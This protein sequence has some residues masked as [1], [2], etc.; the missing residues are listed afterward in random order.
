MFAVL[1]LAHG[2]VIL[3]GLLVKQVQLAVPL[4]AALTSDI[5][6]D[7][8]STSDQ[9]TPKKKPPIKDPDSG[10]SKFKGDTRPKIPRRA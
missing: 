10:D 9:E 4:M 2:G 8:L 6:P 1:F 3:F 7:E 5:E